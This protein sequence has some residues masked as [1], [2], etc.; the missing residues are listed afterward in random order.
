MSNTCCVFLYYIAVSYFLRSV[1][2]SLR[3]IKT[4]KVC[5]GASLA[6]WVLEGTTN[7][8]EYEVMLTLINKTLIK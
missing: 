5:K 6:D 4:E 1:L 3:V 2:G 7:A 8:M